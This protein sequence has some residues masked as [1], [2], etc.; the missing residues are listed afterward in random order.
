MLGEG[1]H[2][3]GLLPHV[4]YE[5]VYSYIFRGRPQVGVRPEDVPG[6]R[7]TTDFRPGDVLV[8]GSHMVHG[9]LRNT[10]DLIRLSLDVRMQPATMERNWQALHSIPEARRLRATASEIAAALGVGDDDFE[11]V[12]AE[13]MKR[14]VA[15]EP[16]PVRHLVDALVLEGLI[17]A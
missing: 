16:G 3:L 14:G 9:A 12:I 5:G 1:S 13:M 6:A 4:P 2:K 8:F 7:L 10:S 11:V 15:P 17:P